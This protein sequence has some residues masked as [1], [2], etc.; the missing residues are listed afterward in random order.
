[1]PNGSFE[2]LSDCPIGADIEK[3]IGWFS[4]T[5]GTPDLYN[6]CAPQI[7]N[8]SVPTNGYGFQNAQDGNGY[9]GIVCYGEGVDYR[10]Y[11]SIRLSKSL[12]ENKLYAV[13]YY[14]NLPEI[15]PKAVNNVGVGFLFNSS[16]LSASDVMNP[17]KVIGNNFIVT[18]T[19]GWTKFQFYYYADGGENYLVIGNFKADNQTQVVEIQ[20]TSGDQY[21]F[22]D[23]VSVL[24]FSDGFENVFTPN[25]DGINDQAFFNPTLDFLDVYIF[26]RWGEIV[27]KINFNDGWD[28][29]DSNGVMLN[30]GVYF[31]SIISTSQEIEFKKTGFIQLVK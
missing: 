27:K 21:Y 5:E 10:E 13:S 12:E 16:Y 9:A 26:N 25:M 24:A 31:Y 23:N 3:A 29:S 22:V 11:I 14:L 7:S 18:D 4:S 2:E 17:D 19:L 1:M 30:E 28:G 6:T 8:L 15:S 20:N